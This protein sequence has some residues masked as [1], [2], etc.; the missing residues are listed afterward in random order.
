[1]ENIDSTQMQLWMLLG[2]F[3]LIRAPEHKN[4]PGGDS[5]HMMLFNNMIQAHNLE[6]IPLKGRNFTWSNMQDSP[7]LEKLDWVFTSA[8]WTIEFPNTLSFPLAKLGSDHTPIHVKIGNDIPKS[9]IFRFENYWMEFDGFIETT[10][11]KWSNAPLIMDSAKNIMSKF[12]ATR[13]GL[14]KWSIYQTSTLLLRTATIPWLF[15]TAW[16]TK[17]IS[18]WWKA[19]S[20]RF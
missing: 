14:K 20:G 4:R 16:K 15:L 7:L 12:K 19:T 11:N 1:M 8:D 17:E 10:M 3:N 2:D 9:C 5:N 13:Y 18:V 6:E